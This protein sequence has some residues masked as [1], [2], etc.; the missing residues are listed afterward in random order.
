MACIEQKTDFNFLNWHKVIGSYTLADLQASG[1]PV[2]CDNIN[3]GWNLSTA[4]Y[5]QS[6]DVTSED[7]SPIGVEF[8]TDG[9]KMY[10]LG[11]STDTVYEYNLSSN[12]N[13]TTAI[14]LQNS[15]VLSEDTAMSSIRFKPDGLK[16]YTIG[17]TNNKVYEYNLSLAWDVTTVAFLQDFSLATQDTSP[18]GVFF[19]SDG[20]KMYVTGNQNDKVYEYD[21]GVA[22]DVTSAV[23]LQDF[24]VSGQDGFPFDIFFKSDGLKMYLIG[25]TNDSIYEYSL[26]SA[27]DI[28]SASISTTKNI[29]A[30]DTS[31]QGLYFKS[32]GTKMY[33]VG[34][35]NN[36]VYE[37]DLTS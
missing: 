24:T 23:I 19:K 22:W 15:G 18:Q 30:Q 9:S 25:S 26:S 33:H 6:F 28:T 1:V 8:N 7:G 4:T 27:W 29:S 31:P 5:L 13:V 12:F 32:D 36:K 11:G 21:L 2:V 14:I 17:D 3:Q 34:D 20:L 35:V 16:M 10:I 37:Y